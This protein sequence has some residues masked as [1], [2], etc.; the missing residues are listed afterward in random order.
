MP[1]ASREKRL[2]Y[3]RKYQELH[4]DELKA[5]NRENRI[6]NAEEIKAK[7]KALIAKNP[8]KYRD[9]RRDT[10]EGI[11]NERARYSEYDKERR[12]EAS[13]ELKRKLC[14]LRYY[15]NKEE[16]NRYSREYNAKNSI[17][18]KDYRAEYYKQNCDKIKEMANEYRKQNPEK[19]KQFCKDW[20]KNNPDRARECWAKRRADKRNAKCGNQKLI[21]EWRRFWSSLEF[22]PCYWCG[23]KI[24]PKIAHADHVLPLTKGGKHSIENLVISCRHCNLSKK[25]SLPENWAKK[26]IKMTFWE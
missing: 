6:N 3:L 21:A 20:V 16:A 22:V 2:E 1:Y 8:E 19:V 10:P 4:K 13:K 24:P 12:P 26:L 7:R 23:K 14:R 15:N 17:K 9:K 18:I 11:A 5:K 25:N